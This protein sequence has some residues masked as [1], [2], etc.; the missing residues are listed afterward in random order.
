VVEDGT[1]NRLIS[2][3][4]T[5]AAEEHCDPAPKPAVASSPAFGSVA[6]IIVARALKLALIAAPPASGGSGVTTCKP[7]PP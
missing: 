3:L 4:L 7:E 1:G 2:P 6:A 5:P